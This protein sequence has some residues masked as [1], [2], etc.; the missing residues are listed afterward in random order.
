MGDFKHF[1]KLVLLKADISFAEPKNA[2]TRGV[3]SIMPSMHSHFNKLSLLLMRVMTSVFIQ[4]TTSAIPK[5]KNTRT[6]F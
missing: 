1:R 6:E 4:V 2:Q 5:S 3:V